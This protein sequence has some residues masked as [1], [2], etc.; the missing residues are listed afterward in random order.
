MVSSRLK[1]FAAEW[2]AVVTM[3]QPAR[4]LE[5]QSSDANLRA[6]LYGSLYVVEA[7]ATRPILSVTAASAESNV[8]GSK[9]AMYCAERDTASM[10][11]SRT[12]GLSARKIIANRPR[13]AVFAIS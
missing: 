6:M 4:P 12:A 11:A 10:F 9:L 13:S 8:I 5:I 2:F 1:F 7:V 3:F